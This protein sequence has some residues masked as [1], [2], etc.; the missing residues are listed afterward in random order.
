MSSS[1]ANARRRCCGG[2]RRP[3]EIA[4]AVRFILDAPA[5]TGQMIAL[6]GGQHLAWETRTRAN[7]MSDAANKRDGR[8]VPAID[9]AHAGR[10]SPR[11]VFVRDLEIVASVGVLEHEKRYEQRI[12]VSADLAVPTTMTAYPTV[13]P[14]CSTTARS[15]MAYPGWCKASTST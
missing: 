15:S 13:W 2:A 10:R 4:A 8:T 3:Q 9:A 7:Q 12:I 14:T 5:M 1:G 6:D 11:R